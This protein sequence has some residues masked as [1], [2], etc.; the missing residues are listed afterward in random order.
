MNNILHALSSTFTTCACGA[1]ARNCALTQ[2]AAFVDRLEGVKGGSRE[3]DHEEPPVDLGPLIGAKRGFRTKERIGGSGGIGGMVVDDDNQ[4][5]ESEREGGETMKKTNRKGRMNGVNGHASTSKTS[6]N[7][8]T[9]KRGPQPGI[10][11]RRPESPSSMPSPAVA[12]M[13]TAVVGYGRNKRKDKGKQ[14]ALPLEDGE[15]GVVDDGTGMLI[16]I[17]FLFAIFSFFLLL[18]YPF[19][20]FFPS[21]FPYFNRDSHTS[22][23]SSRIRM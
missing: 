2:M 4:E 23:A 14:K 18:S 19:F 1:R 11:V 17:I 16:F 8:T 21:F 7:T 20:C 10:F 6:T 5:D 22:P 9:P 15:N 13:N 12:A 3:K